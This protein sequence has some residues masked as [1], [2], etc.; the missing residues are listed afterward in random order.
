MI[1]V[2]YGKVDTTGSDVVISAEFI[3]LVMEMTR[4]VGE[5]KTVEAFNYALKTL[6]EGE[7]DGEA[8][9]NNN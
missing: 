7:K 5:E 4:K 3:S 1:K 8:E 9:V 2:S 6:H